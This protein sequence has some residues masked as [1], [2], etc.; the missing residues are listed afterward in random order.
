M[1]KRIANSEYTVIA[2]LYAG[3]ISLLTLGR[4]YD[5]T[6]QTIRN[7]LHRQGVTL[8]RR[9]GVKKIP[10]EC[11]GRLPD[12]SFR[13][14]HKRTPGAKFRQRLA[15]YRLTPEAFEGLVG[16]AK[17]SCEL[18]GESFNG[19]TPDIDH[20]HAT[21]RVRGLIHGRCNRLL[22]H[23]LDSPDVLLKAVAY[24]EKHTATH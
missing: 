18:C 10:A 4:A 2:E 19:K 3:G 5:V 6:Y 16:R 13:S 21:G 17:G 12:R 7:V 1:R 14:K 20:D 23:A 22:G 9:G 11:A 24:L 15:R 8:R